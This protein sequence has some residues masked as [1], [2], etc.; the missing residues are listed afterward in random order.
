VTPFGTLQKQLQ[1]TEA[2]AWLGAG[3][4]PLLFLRPPDRRIAMGQHEIDEAVA[5]AT[6]ETPGFIHHFG[7]SIADPLEVHFDPEPRRP[8]VLDWD[9]MAP[10]EWHGW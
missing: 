1:F 5:R 10:A 2:T 7:F 8:L 9:T 4:S 6:G 3:R